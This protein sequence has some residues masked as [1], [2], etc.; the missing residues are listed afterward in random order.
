MLCKTWVARILGFSRG[1]IIRRRAMSRGSAGKAVA[2][3]ATLALFCAAPLARSSIEF[4][5]RTPLLTLKDLNEVSHGAN[6][7]TVHRVLHLTHHAL[8][9]HLGVAMVQEVPDLA[10]QL[11]HFL[12]HLSQAGVEREGRGGGG[13]GGSRCWRDGRQASTCKSRANVRMRISNRTILERKRA[14]GVR[15]RGTRPFSIRVF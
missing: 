1:R 2:R 6:G 5:R 13:A 11:Q 14:S 15:E 8:D 3:C 10:N 12:M 4:K 9:V 7:V